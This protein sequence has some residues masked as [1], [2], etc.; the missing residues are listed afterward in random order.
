MNYVELVIA[1][2]QEWSA[3]TGAPLPVDARMIA[4]SEIMGEVVDLCTGETAG[5][6]A[7]DGDVRLATQITLR[8]PLAWLA[9]LEA[10]CDGN[11][12]IAWAMTPEAYFAEAERRA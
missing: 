5:Y 12:R 9:D 10:A 4:A 11:V 2:V 8:S 1:D 7:P 3:E 6:E